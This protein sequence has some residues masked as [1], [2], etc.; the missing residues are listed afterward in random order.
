MTTAGSADRDLL[1]QRAEDLE[2]LGAFSQ[3]GSV[4]S[5]KFVAF[6]YEQ[7]SGSI[8]SYKVYNNQSQATVFEAMRVS[9]L[10]GANG[11]LDLSMFSASSPSVQLM[12]HNIPWG[13]IHLAAANETTVTIGLAHGANVMAINHSDV[14]GTDRTAVNITFSDVAGTLAVIHGSIDISP[15]QGNLTVNIS[16]GGQ[17]FFRA[18]AD[19][20]R[21]SHGGQWLTM[22]YLIRGAISSELWALASNTSAVYDL[23]QFHP[24]SL[25]LAS[26]KVNISDLEVGVQAHSILLVHL[27]QGSIG[28]LNSFIPVGMAT[29]TVAATNIRDDLKAWRDNSTE[30]VRYIIRNGDVTTA[31][32]Y[33]P[34][35]ASSP[36]LVLGLDHKSSD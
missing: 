21:I 26:D 6:N 9:S 2:M 31:A 23:V 33:V 14:W 19:Y 20:T 36:K 34:A 12:V 16:K 30:P 17:L 7:G 11:T 5:G 29:D 28:H 24:G 18:F 3:S 15:D 22:D 4:I 32:M 13:T 25:S 8:T 1:L 35:G 10:A 27:D